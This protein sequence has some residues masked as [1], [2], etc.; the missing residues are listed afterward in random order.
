MALTLEQALAR[1]PMWCDA[2][3]LTT[4]PLGGGITNQNFRVDVGGESF[5]LRI[6]GA[7]TELLGINRQHEYAANVA[8]A[9]IGIAPEVIY[10]VE[11][12]GYLV[13]RFL[14]ARPIPRDEMQ[15]PENIRRVAHALKQIH[16]LP[17]IPGTFSPF[18]T[19]ED[20]AATARRYNVAFPANF[21]WL[22]ARLS[23]IEA[24][25]AREPFVPRPCHND[26][27]NE[28]FLDDGNIHVIDWE[29]AG[30]GDIAFD[31]ANFA[32]HHQLD[33]E[34]GQA[35]LSE[36]F[37]DVTARHVARHKLMKI[38]SDIRE[39]MWAMVQIGISK[40]DFDF[41]GYADKHF[42]RAEGMAREA[43]YAEWLNAFADVTE[44]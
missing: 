38:G 25:F 32:V 39:A 13:T 1:V 21:D 37:S 30:M 24:A 20:Y 12:E 7:D 23:E 28:N 34:Q 26:L 16:A 31:L 41:R 10:F 9:R 35:L 8:A 36:Y 3:D 2:R 6:G 19:I 27:L 11:P 43:R 4:S 40:L 15:Q 42:A 22:M 14:Q 5:V 29:Y 44:R 33:D 18:R 17:A